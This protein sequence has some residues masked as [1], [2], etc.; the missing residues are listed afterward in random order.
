M[1]GTAVLAFLVCEGLRC[2]WIT[3]RMDQVL[4]GIVVKSDPR[5][6]TV[7]PCRLCTRLAFAP[8]PPPSSSSSTWQAVHTDHLWQAVH[9]DH[10]WQAVHTDHLCHPHPSSS[11]RLCTE[12]AFRALPDAGV[13]EMQRSELSGLVLQLK[14]LG[15][16]NIMAF[17][18]LAAPPAEAMVRAL[19][20]LHA[21]GALGED[22]RLTQVGSWGIC[23][24]VVQFIR[25]RSGVLVVSASHV[26]HV[27]WCSYLLQGD[28]TQP[29]AAPRALAGVSTTCPPLP[30]GRRHAF[31]HAAAGPCPWPLP[32]KGRRAGLR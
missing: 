18:W 19:E 21:L 23:C 24:G 27:A 20:A 8:L 14:A 2:W 12:E 17:E 26:V 5:W 4:P 11:L 7:H 22:A 32:A 16:D 28:A 9:T 15:V 30:A 1:P 10:L 25:Y 3:S 6:R 29:R 31:V 13:P